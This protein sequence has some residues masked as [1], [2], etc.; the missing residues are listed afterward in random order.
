MQYLLLLLFNAIE[1]SLGSSSPY[2]SNKEEEIYLNK[3]IQKHSKY[4]YLYVTK[5][6]TQLSK[7]PTYYKTNTYIHTLTHSRSHKNHL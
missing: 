7:T 2:I 6:T 1:F 3:T 4:K 5:T